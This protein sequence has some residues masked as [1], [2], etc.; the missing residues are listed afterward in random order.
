[1]V[2]ADISAERNIMSINNIEDKKAILQTL[3]KEELVSMIH[4]LLAE[5]K[6]QKNKLVTE[7]TNMRFLERHLKKIRD[8][9]DTTLNTK[10]EDTDKIWSPK[11]VE[12]EKYKIQ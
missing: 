12:N 3:E 7:K 9:I 10:V 11:D 2:P 6:K 1:M 8:Q 4:E 5:L